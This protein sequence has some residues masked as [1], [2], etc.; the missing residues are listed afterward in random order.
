MSASPEDRAT[1]NAF[2]NSWNHQVSGSVYTSDQF[3]DWLD[4]IAPESLT[5]TEVLEMGFGNGSLLLHAG[6]CKPRRLVGI[7]LGN[8]L[9]TARRNLRELPLP[10]VELHRGDLT[11]AELGQ[12]DTVYCIGV[13]HHLKQPRAGFEAVLRHTRPGGRFHCWVYGYEGNAVVRHLVD[14]LRRM[15]S[16][17]PWW[18]TKYFLALP[19]SVPF[20]LY[21]KGLASLPTGLTEWLPLSAYARWIARREFGFFHHVAFDQLVTP[22]TCYLRRHEVESLMNHPLVEPSSTYLIHRNGNSW[23][24]GGRRRQ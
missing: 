15:G 8:T 19:L 2:A 20:Y 11:V 6:R 10:M 18:F 14:P 13:L 23:K 7:E 24:F 5:G 21:C 9:E 4:P 16:R 22:Q 1:A 3:V 12:F 17:L